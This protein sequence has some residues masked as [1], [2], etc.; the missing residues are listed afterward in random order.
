MEPYAFENMPIKWC[1]MQ[2]NDLKHSSK[3]VKSWFNTEKIDVLDWPAQS[4]DLNPIENLWNE[5]KWQGKTIKRLMI[6]GLPFRNHG[7]PYLTT[8]ANNS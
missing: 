1:F 5:I 3:L 2:D 8:S 7:T 4:P 6:F